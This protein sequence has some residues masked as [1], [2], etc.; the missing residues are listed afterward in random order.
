MGIFGDRSY[1]QH[2]EDFFLMNLMDLLKIEKPSWLEFGSHHPEIDSNTKLFY[3]R[4]FHGV[5]VE[6]N[7]S[8]FQA[9]L[10]RRPKD[11]NLNVGVGPRADI[12]PFYM[13]E[14]NSGLNSF[15]KEEV[16]RSG[17]SIT[18]IIEL[19]VVTPQAILEECCEGRWPD[20][21]LTDIEG[22]DHDVLESCQFE[23]GNRPKVI[24]SEIRP[25]HSFK[26]KDLMAAK[27]YTT[28][29]RLTANLIFVSSEL[30]SQVV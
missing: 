4:G 19:P 12:M 29:C 23:K 16:E 17:R 26:T 14:E 20:I 11:V 15:C 28:L 13:V 18:K 24:C 25:W 2:G 5:N 7:P 9:F 21:L 22:L 8:L 27:G 1:A 3:E 30:C 10:E 6:A